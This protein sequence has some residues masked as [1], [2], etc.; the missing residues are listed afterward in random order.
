MTAATSLARVHSG[1]MMRLAQH[2]PFGFT[3]YVFEEPHMDTDHKPNRTVVSNKAS[4]TVKIECSC[5]DKFS[6][7]DPVAEKASQATDLEYQTHLQET[8]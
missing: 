3:G 4:V 8:R 1:G 7:R 2:L 6:N 5:G